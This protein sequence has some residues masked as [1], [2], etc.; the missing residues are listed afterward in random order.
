MRISVPCHPCFTVD[1]SPELHQAFWRKLR[2]KK[3]L[4]RNSFLTCVS[5]LRET[6]GKGTFQK[7]S[8]HVYLALAGDSWKK[9]FSI[10]LAIGLRQDLWRILSLLFGTYEN[11]ISLVFEQSGK[12]LVHRRES[13]TIL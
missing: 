13:V 4:F 3:S 8:F 12:R 6:H 2:I 7:F 9:E 5:H 11:D 1:L 10:D